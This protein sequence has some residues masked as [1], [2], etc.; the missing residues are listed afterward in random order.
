MIT[1]Q[2]VHEM[3]ILQ[4]PPVFEEQGNLAKVWSCMQKNDATHVKSKSQ[5]LPHFNLNDKG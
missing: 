3:R 5:Y 4:H 1:G 2:N